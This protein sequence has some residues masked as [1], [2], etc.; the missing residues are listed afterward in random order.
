[1]VGAGVA[2][3]TVTATV[4]LASLPS[5]LYAALAVALALASF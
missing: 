5:L 2:P 1:M 3:V 4:I